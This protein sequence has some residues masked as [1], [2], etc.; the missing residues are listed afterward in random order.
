[1]SGQV[2]RGAAGDYQSDEQAGV[3]RR[4][5]YEQYCH[6]STGYL[7]VFLTILC[8]NKKNII[9]IDIKDILIILH[10]CKI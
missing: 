4:D 6:L 8:F 9:I 10:S 3:A 7:I 2:S 5:I 1:M